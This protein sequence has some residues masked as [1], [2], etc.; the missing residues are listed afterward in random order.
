MSLRLGRLMRCRILD[1]IARGINKRRGITFAY[2]GSHALSDIAQTIVAALIA[3]RTRPR[4]RNISRH[5]SRNIA[6]EPF[7]VSK[8]VVH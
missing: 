8:N 3:D 6:F 5:T 4:A 7:G 1:A 2:V